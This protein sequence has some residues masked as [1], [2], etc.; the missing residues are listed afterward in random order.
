MKNIE[1]ALCEIRDLQK[2]SQFFESELEKARQAA[3]HSA[4]GK[5]LIRYGITCMKIGEHHK[6]LDAVR[7]AEKIAKGGQIEDISHFLGLAYFELGEFPEAINFL[8]RV[9]VSAQVTGD[10]PAE[11]LYLSTLGRA[12]QELWRNTKG[13]QC[14]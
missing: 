12:Y 10:R 2:I 8:E 14:F 6:A 7:Q 5:L 11:G 1:N 9:V 13:S 4:E 3:D